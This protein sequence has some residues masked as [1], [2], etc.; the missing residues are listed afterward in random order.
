MRL[1][2]HALCDRDASIAGPSVACFAAA[3]R[4]ETLPSPR[5]GQTLVSS[6]HS[7]LVRTRRSPPS[8]RL[9]AVVGYGLAF[10]MA[11]TPRIAGAAFELD[12]PSSFLPFTGAGNLISSPADLAGPHCLR[13]QLGHQVLFGLRQLSGHQLSAA[14]S[15][16]RWG[17]GTGLSLRGPGRNRET[18]TW[19]GG[20]ISPVPNLAVGAGIHLLQLRQGNH[21]S[22]SG[23]TLSGGVRLQIGLSMS[24]SAWLRGPA[25]DLAPPR[26]LIGL[27]RILGDQ[28]A[29]EGHMTRRG[30]R[31]RPN[32][33]H[34]SAATLIHPRLW[35]L[36]GVRSA[37]IQFA[38]GSRLEAGS[39]FL[40]FRLD[41]HAVL[42]TSH[43][44][45]VGRDCGPRFEP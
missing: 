8:R 23:F 37:P 22:V 3:H 38:A 11:E 39:H 2:A 13:W 44:A 10:C 7:R 5:T 15:R 9:L 4:V 17:L 42:G 21:P 33:L 40:E 28:S 26:L 24:L 45:L 41:T 32:R 12:D 16:R 19:L 43:S 36:L 1:A 18:A 30:G 31:Y 34:L 29:L 6:R 14:I 25:G 35:L 27:T 20:G